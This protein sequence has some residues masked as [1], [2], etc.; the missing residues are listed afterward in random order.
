[1]LGQ[2]LL[3][4]SSIII[5]LLGVLHLVYTFFTDKFYPRDTT[6][7]TT[8]QSAV[9]IISSQTTIWK[10]L[11]GFN[12]SHSI[13]FILFGLIYSYLAIKHLDF[14]LDTPFLLF[15]G[16]C[17]LLSYVIL[18]KIYWFKVPFTGIVIATVFYV[19]GLTINY[20]CC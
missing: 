3:I 4:I 7:L 12:A 17:T 6:L 2:I 1:M 8:L 14:L 16:L 18:A 13:G 20:Y 5:L 15:V 19:V 10:G 11:L 9:P